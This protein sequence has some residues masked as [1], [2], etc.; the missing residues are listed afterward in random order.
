MRGA[1][2]PDVVG[3]GPEVSGQEPGINS[4]LRARLFATRD[5]GTEYSVPTGDA[6]GASINA[7]NSPGIDMHPAYSPDGQHIAFTSNRDGNY[8]IY[9]MDADSAPL[10]SRS[11]ARY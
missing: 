1:Y 7:T 3:Q 9:V 5:I 8:E 2:E 11:W 4:L 10:V 6:L